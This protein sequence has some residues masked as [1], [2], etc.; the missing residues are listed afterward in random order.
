[1]PLFGPPNIEKMKAKKDVEGLI[2]ALSYQKDWLLR[3]DAAQALGDLA[4]ARSVEPL[5]AALDDE[6]HEV[7]EYAAVALGRIGGVRTTELLI[8]ALTDGSGS[9]GVR[10]SAAKALGEIGDSRA[11]ESLIAALED[12]NH[13]VSEYAAAALGRIGGARTTELLI[14]AL[15]DVSLSG[16]V[17]SSAAKALVQI[18]A[19]SVESLIV[20]FSQAIAENDNGPRFSQTKDCLIKIGEP[21]VQPLAILLDD[22]NRRKQW[23]AA[24][25]L[26][27]IG[28]PQA[29][30]PLIAALTDQTK[31]RDD[32]VEVVEALG[33]IGDPRAIPHLITRLKS[34]P[35]K[36]TA[37][38]LERIGWKPGEDEVSAWYWVARSNYQRASALGSV[39]VEPLIYATRRGVLSAVEGLVKVGAPVE[40]ILVDLFK[41][42]KGNIRLFAVKALV[43]HVGWKLEQA[44]IIAWYRVAKEEYETAANLGAV[45]IEPLIEAI[46]I[47]VAGN[48]KV[49]PALVKI[50][51]PAVEPLIAALTAESDEWGRSLA[52]ETLGIIG[53]RRAVD[54]LINLLQDDDESVRVK[55]YAAEALGKIG[56]P[57]AI[58]PI[59]ALLKTVEEF[60]YKQISGSLE[61]FSKVDVLVA[62]NDGTV[63]D[64]RSGLL[65]QQADDGGERTYEDALTYCR[66]LR[67]AGHDDWRL[68]TKEE[69]N[70]L[71]SVSPGTLKKKFPDIIRGR[72]WAHTAISELNWAEAPERIAYTVDFD[73]ESGNYRKPITYFKTYSYHVRAVRNTTG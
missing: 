13:K 40:D 51:K 33:K 72:Y 45:A 29:V 58:R 44:E 20:E 12:K 27:E 47:Y 61:A 46:D 54:A 14:A 39:A 16:D 6:N 68:P 59:T 19:P 55:T 36:D 35:S 53:D 60:W 49:I 28:S 3:Q 10:S 48:Q 18:G 2:K 1:M 11:V 17:R 62:N 7:S 63:T 67:I 38:A 52:A 22:P 57:R 65:W 4:D 37:A 30:E 42:D 71:A 15:T 73:P 32:R 9:E 8:T 31:S 24:Q 64:T 23:L 70:E 25:M 34:N 5:I 50:G 21:S 41:N 56:D 43:E 69:L 66:S 26:G